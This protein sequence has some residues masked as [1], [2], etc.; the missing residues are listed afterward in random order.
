MITHILT[1]LK[2]IIKIGLGNS[3]RL[4]RGRTYYDLNPILCEELLGPSSHAARNDNRGILLVQPPGQQAGLM[5]GRRQRLCVNN[6]FFFRIHINQ[7][8]FLTMTE[9]WA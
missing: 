3:P 1:G 4:L 2:R 6:L 8:E 9:V 5:L 7:S